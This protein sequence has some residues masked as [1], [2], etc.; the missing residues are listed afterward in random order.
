MQ[1]KKKLDKGNENAKDY[2]VK[3]YYFTFNLVG[4]SL[5]LS[6]N[7][8]LLLIQNRHLLL[9]DLDLP[10]E[11][12]ALQSLQLCDGPRFILHTGNLFNSTAMTILDHDKEIYTVIIFIILC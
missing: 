12:N 8:S 10:V 6:S 5:H 9:L 7:Q 2:Y 11:H 3:I 4:N 1:C